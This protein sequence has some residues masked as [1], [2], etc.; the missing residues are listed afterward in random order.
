[1]SNSTAALN[2]SLG[3][4]LVTQFATAICLATLSPVTIISNILLLL[5]IAKDPLKC[6]RT[7]VTYFIV[8]L[9]LADLMTG[10]FVE[11]FYVVF[12]LAQYSKWSL[13][14]GERYQTF[15]EIGNTLSYIGLNTSFLLV[16]GLIWCQY[17]AITFPHY[18]RAAVTTRKVVACILF[19]WLYFTA[20][21][22]LKFAGVPSATLFKVDLHLHSTLITVLLIIGSV[23]LLRS[24]RAFAKASRRLAGERSVTNRSKRGKRTSGIYEKQFT[25]VTLLLSVILV[26]CSLP[27]IIVIHI[28][29]Y[30]TQATLQEKLDLAIAVTIADEMMF[31][32]VALDAFIYAWRLAKYRRSLRIVLTCRGS[33]ITSSVTEMRTLDNLTMQQ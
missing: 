24:L 22:I 31:L 13:S 18:F 25:I 3:P 27:H 26:V 23:N 28:K 8:A 15:V 11:P 6:F 21:I 12:R 29:Y 30:S 20:F 16:L 7:P 2:T 19:S 5:A 10:L 9:A 1:M 33:R 4:F 14:P 32:K 17:I